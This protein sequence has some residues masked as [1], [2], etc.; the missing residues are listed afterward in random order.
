MAPPIPSTP[1]GASAGYTAAC[2]SWRKVQNQ[3]GGNGPMFYLVFRDAVQ[4]LKTDKNDI[5]DIGLNDGQTYSY[6]VAAQDQSGTSAQSPASLVTTPEQV[7]S[8]FELGLIKIGPGNPNNKVVGSPPMIWL[9]TD[10][11][12]NTTLYV[13]E[14]GI[15]TRTGWVAK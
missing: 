8:N 5:T 7:D 6:T 11:G 15:N 1:V 4:I 13:K 12:A 3:Q 9:R 2:I 10:G 14:S